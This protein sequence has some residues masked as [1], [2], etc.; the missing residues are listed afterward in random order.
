MIKRLLILLALA[1]GLIPHA[2]AQTYQLPSNDTSAAAGNGVTKWNPLF[3]TNPGTGNVWRFNRIFC[4]EATFSSGDAGPVSRKDWLE[5]LLANTT[6]V[7]E[8]ICIDTTGQLGVVGA[9]RSSDYRT[10]FSGASGGS[11]GLTGIGYNNDTTGAPIAVGENGLGM[12]ASGVSGVTVGHQGDINNGGS[13]VDIEPNT[14]I[15]GGS[16]IGML[17]TSGA[18]SG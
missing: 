7:A 10:T 9:S 18:Y 11:Q 8:F 12:R 5:T 16:N 1:G 17:S 15:L 3:F 13:V 2:Y 14:G 6:G 4:G